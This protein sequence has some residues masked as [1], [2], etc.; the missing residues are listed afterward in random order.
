MRAQHHESLNRLHSIAGLIQLDRNDDAL[1]LIIDEITDE[2]AVI[3]KLRDNIHDYSIQGLL[4]GKHSR[5]KELGIHLNLD[6]E[7]YLLDFMTGFSSGDMVTIIGNLLD[8]AMEA[9]LPKEIRDVNILIQGDKHFLFIEVQ[10]SG[11]GIKGNPNKIFEYG[12]STK[13]R[14]GHGIG[15]A[16]IKQIIESNKGT[17]HVATEVNIGTTI[18]IK[19]GVRNS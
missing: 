13:K 5:A 4:L 3:Q 2:E 8:N 18:M 15:M 17:I 16:L 7:S 1:S 11:V 6:D 19:A 10:D 12:Y 9:C 14:E